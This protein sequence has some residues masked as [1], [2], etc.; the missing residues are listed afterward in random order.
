MTF[1]DARKLF[2]VLETIA[3]LNA[4]TFGPLAEPVARAQA[5]SLE[6]DLARGARVASVASWPPER[7]MQNGVVLSDH[8]VVEAHVEAGPA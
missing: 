6:H 1:A 3:Y 7:R 5:E 4:G 8:P 2:P